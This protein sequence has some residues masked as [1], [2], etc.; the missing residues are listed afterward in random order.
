MVIARGGTEILYNLQ[1]KILLLNSHHTL[2][3]L[4]FELQFRNG[5]L[6]PVLFTHEAHLRLAW[7]HIRKYGLDKAID[8][9]TTQIKSY[10]AKLGAS[11][12][13]NDTVTVAAVYAVQHFISK[14]ESDQFEDFIKNH[15]VLINDF[16][17]LLMSHYKTDIFKS[18]EAKKKFLKPELT[19][20]EN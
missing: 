18:A 17:S 20:F 3:D 19:P 9:V 16:R 12:K 4:E 2:S 8:N 14:K 5:S 7:I 10:V 11:D 15:P 6:D 13:Y 1:F